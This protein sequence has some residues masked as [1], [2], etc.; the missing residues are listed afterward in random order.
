[1]SKMNGQGHGLRASRLLGLVV[2]LAS[3]AAAYWLVAR[4]WLLSW[5]ST[6][7]D[8]QRVLPGDDVAPTARSVTTRAIT[9]G[10]PPPAIWPWLVQMGQDRAGFYTHNWV[11]RLLL[12]GIPDIEELHPEWQTLRAGDLVRTNRDIM[13]RAL[14]WPVAGIDPERSLVLRSNGWPVGTFA[15][16]LEQADGQG[17]R[18]IVR[19]RADWR[20]WQWPFRALLYEPLHAYMQTGL[21]QGVKR[22]VEG[23]RTGP[24]T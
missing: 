1:M 6:D 16:V 22:R 19:D 15:F 21:M 7:D 18:L 5:G 4:P 24:T 17:T 14:G 2:G 3:A 11:E 12:S 23:R 20:W 8:R 10:A 9:I 13:G